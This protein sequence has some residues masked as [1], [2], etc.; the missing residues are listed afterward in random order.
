MEKEAHEE[1]DKD[2][3]QE[4]T[5]DFCTALGL[6]IEIMVMNH[7]VSFADLA[8]ESARPNVSDQIL[9]AGA[10]ASVRSTQPMLQC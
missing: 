3:Q 6:V 9:L 2:R 1:A 5:Y 8:P 4:P 7:A 10:T